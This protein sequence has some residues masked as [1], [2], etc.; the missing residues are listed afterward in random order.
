MVRSASSI[1]FLRKMSKSDEIDTVEW[2]EYH[3]LDNVRGG[4]ISFMKG[5]IRF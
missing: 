1:L 2:T 3:K 5:N 4:Q